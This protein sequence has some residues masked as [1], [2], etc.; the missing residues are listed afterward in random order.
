MLPVEHKTFKRTGT[1]C[2]SFLSEK[3]RFF[4][5]KH[6]F[7]EWRRRKQTPAP[8]FFG[9]GLIRLATVNAKCKIKLP[10]E[11]KKRV[12]KSDPAKIEQH[13]A[14]FDALKVVQAEAAADPA[15][16]YEAKKYTGIIKKLGGIIIDIEK[17]NAM[18]DVSVESK[19][20]TAPATAGTENEVVRMVNGR[21]AIY[22]SITK[23]FIRW[24][25]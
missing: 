14:M 16:S 11:Q 2:D 6:P 1:H 23:K 4:T 3:L 13:V 8:L 19:S 17:S 15:R 12:S 9:R 22:N 7:G 5:K 24:G 18:K 10:I 21:K 25:E 20:A